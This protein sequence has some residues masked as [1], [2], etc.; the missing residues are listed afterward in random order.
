VLDFV[1]EQTDW[2]VGIT[3]DE[4]DRNP[5]LDRGKLLKA[6]DGCQM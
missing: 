4:A 3:C 6:N 1:D 2:A 5:D